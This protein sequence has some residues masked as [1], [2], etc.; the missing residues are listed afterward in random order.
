MLSAKLDRQT[1]NV[2]R[3]LLGLRH[4]A[5]SLSRH[6]DIA[7]TVKIFHEYAPVYKRLRA[8][9]DAG[10]RTTG[11]QIAYDAGVQ[12]DV[13]LTTQTGCLSDRIHQ[14]RLGV[15]ELQRDW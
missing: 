6:L 10:Y 9:A 11:A 13:A 4:D 2:V 3:R 1:T 5:H 12:A 7:A 15:G 8:D 14:L